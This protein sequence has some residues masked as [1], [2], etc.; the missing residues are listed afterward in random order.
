[1]DDNDVPVWMESASGEV[2]KFS[3]ERYMLEQD[4]LWHDPFLSL[5]D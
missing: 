3:F 1:M 4:K 5:E 2:E